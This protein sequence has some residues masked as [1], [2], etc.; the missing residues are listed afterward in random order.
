[1]KKKKKKWWA[2]NKKKKRSLAEVAGDDGRRKKKAIASLLYLSVEEKGREGE[3]IFFHPSARMRSI[4]GRRTPLS[5]K[6]VDRSRQ[7]GEG[8]NDI[9]VSEEGR[10]KIGNSLCGKGKNG[11]KKNGRKRGR[12]KKL[13]PRSEEGRGGGV[14][15]LFRVLKKREEG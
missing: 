9:A 6:E 2:A 3:K 12:G 4:L 8:F 1:V 15:V 7:V 14:C 10:G 13:G 11:Q 5:E